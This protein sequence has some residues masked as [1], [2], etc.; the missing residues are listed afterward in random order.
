MIYNTNTK[1]ERRYILKKI[2]FVI[3]P[4]VIM[5][6][7]AVQAGAHQGRTDANGG[8][9]SS[10]GYH[11]HH[12]Y[13]AHQHTNG[14]CPYNYDDKTNHQSGN[15]SN[16]SE[17]SVSTLS[18]PK[19]T[20]ATTKAVAET[21]S[22]PKSSTTVKSNKSDDTET[23]YLCII[24]YF[25][26]A[27]VVFSIHKML[28]PFVADNNFKNKHQILADIFAFISVVCAIYSFPFLFIDLI[29]SI[30]R[31]RIRDKDEEENLKSCR[32]EYYDKGYKDGL[33]KTDDKHNNEINAAWD[34]GYLAGFKDGAD[35]ADTDPRK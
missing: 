15:T 28:W 8:H 2:S 16:K 17:S 33:K 30:P 1:N 35:I 25:I 32:K 24:I 3:I 9:N 11:Y 4:I 34:K 20:E 7:F 14:K 23:T 12:G 10:S 21:T 5:L 26:S 13:P 18:K 22:K 6:I 19:E 27:I 31:E 29:N